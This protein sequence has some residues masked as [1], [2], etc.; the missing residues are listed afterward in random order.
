M[1][2]RLAL[3]IYNWWLCIISVLISILALM[4]IIILLVIV[5]G[6]TLPKLPLSI[7]V[8]T[9]ISFCATIAKAT[10]LFAV[11]ESLSQLKWL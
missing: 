3:F 1:P 9:Y 8:N 11:A 7:T 2:N 10:M 5:D 6:K 4:A